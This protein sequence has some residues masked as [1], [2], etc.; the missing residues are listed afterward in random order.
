MLSNYKTIRTKSY[1]MVAQQNFFSQQSDWLYE[2]KNL[3]KSG[4]FL[5]RGNTAEV[6][7]AKHQDKEILI[8]KYKYKNLLH[9]IRQSPR[10]PRPQRCWLAGLRLQEY[11]IPTPKPLGY[12]AEYKNGLFGGGYLITEYFE[13]EYLHEFFKQRKQSNEVLRQVAKETI[14]IFC[15]LEKAKIVHGDMKCTNI[16][17]VNNHPVVIDL[18]SIRFCNSISYL[19]RKNKDRKRF[20][21]EIHRFPYL[22]DFFGEML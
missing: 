1:K 16:L 19:R 21:R 4:T 18:D 3:F 14:E 5:K 13:N 22:Q 7:K 15:L 11:K 10:I 12:I 8:K 9:S 17:I 20:Q 2:L 6:V